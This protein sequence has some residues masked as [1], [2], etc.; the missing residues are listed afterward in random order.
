MS[1]QCWKIGKI[2]GVLLLLFILFGL[3]ASPLTVLAQGGNVDL[4]LSLASGGYPSQVKAGENN[5]FFVEVRNIGNTTLTNIQ[6]S[7]IVNCDT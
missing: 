2:G 6:L 4:A 3:I 5:T 7:S 1:A